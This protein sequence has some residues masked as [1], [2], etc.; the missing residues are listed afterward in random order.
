MFRKVVRI[1]AL[2]L[3]FIKNISKKFLKVQKNIIFHHEWPGILPDVLKINK[4][5]YILTTGS[6]TCAGGK[7][8]EMSDNMLKVSN[9]LLLTQSIARS[10][11]I[12]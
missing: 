8:I 7:V 9:V 4:D 6:F 1:L 5:K 10:Q 3:T 11:A 2:V 12:S